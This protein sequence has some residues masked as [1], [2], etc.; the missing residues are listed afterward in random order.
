MKSCFMVL[1]WENEGHH[2]MGDDAMFA[3]VGNEAYCILNE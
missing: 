3:M 1:A 2:R